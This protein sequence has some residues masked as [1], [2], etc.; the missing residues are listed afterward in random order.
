LRC[1]NSPPN[2]RLPSPGVASSA[3]TGPAFR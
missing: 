1:R 2:R 3:V